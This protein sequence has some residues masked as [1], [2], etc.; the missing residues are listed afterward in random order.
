MFYPECKEFPPSNRQPET[1][2]VTVI[3]VT[4]AKG[5]YRTS[6]NGV[7][8]C[9]I[10]GETGEK[11]TPTSGNDVFPD[12]STFFNPLDLEV[13]VGV[14]SVLSGEDSV[15]Y[16]TD[17][18]AID[19]TREELLRLMGYKLTPDEYMALRTRY[20]MFVEIH[21]DFYSEATGRQIQPMF[22]EEEEHENDPQAGNPK[23]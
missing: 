16:K 22:P 12:G 20:G 10:W 19:L 7:V 6:P 8:G 11:P 17:D 15:L 5:T 13:R 21:D 3:L 18:L 14:P 4:D 1:L 23:P 2:P 9:V